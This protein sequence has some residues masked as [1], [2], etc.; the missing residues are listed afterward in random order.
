MI[1]LDPQRAELRGTA[2]DWYSSHQP[3]SYL[4]HVTLEFPA[5][6]LELEL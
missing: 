6:D 2:I 5:P 1:I 4:A 3:I